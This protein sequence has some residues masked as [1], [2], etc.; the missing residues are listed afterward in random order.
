MVKNI[1]KSS[2]Y[3]I[4]YF[5][6]QIM[7]M[8]GFLAVDIF[9]GVFTFSDFQNA[10]LMME[11]LTTYLYGIAIPS[12]I[13]SAAI[14]FLIFILYK[15]IRKHP[16]DFKNVEISKFAFFVCVGIILNIVITALVNAVAIVLPPELLN[17]LSES[18]NAALTGSPFLLLLIGTGILVPILE[19][20]VFRYGLCGTLSRSN[21]IFALIASA[22]I[23]GIVH[24]NIIQAVY[25]S[26]LGLIFG[27]VYLKTNN[28][29]YP[30]ALHMAVNSS[31]VIVAQFEAIW[32]YIVFAV[33]A[34]IGI[35]LL[36]HKRPEIKQ[37][38]KK[39][40]VCIDE[41]TDTL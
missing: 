8:V 17:S 7:G 28:I 19:E 22:L 20:L 12:L 14:F 35:I 38:F 34:A 11:E 24:G 1:L 15:K 30:I 26:A 4:L 16:F 40:N 6:L 41:N 21:K 23:F 5:V 18:T 33:I 29:W 13:V 37:L 25:A 39:E 10:D 9:S 27:I 32:L 3:F 36:V 31:S 2:V